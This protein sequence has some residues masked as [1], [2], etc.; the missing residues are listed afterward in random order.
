MIYPLTQPNRHS[1][2]IGTTPNNG[3]YRERKLYY[4]TNQ[5]SNWKEE[6]NIWTVLILLCT[7]CSG[8]KRKGMNIAARY[9]Y[10]YLMSYASVCVCAH[11]YQ[12][13]APGNQSIQCGGIHF[14]EWPI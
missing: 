3:A 14:P 13:D 11:I 7:F 2:L 12:T 9:S 1:I 8:R 5:Q 4:V 6:R 10:S